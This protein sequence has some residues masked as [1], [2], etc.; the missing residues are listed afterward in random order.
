MTLRHHSIVGA[1]VTATAVTS[2]A[3]V[4]GALAA[5]TAASAASGA[6]AATASYRA[7][8]QFTTTG[9]PRDLLLHPDS[10]KL[11]VGSAD[12]PD[13]T[14]VNENGLYVLDP[15]DGKVRSTVGRAPGPTGALGPRAVGRFAGPLPGDGAAFVYPL[16]GIGTAKDGDPAVTGGWLPGATVTDVG[17]G[18]TPGTVLVAQGSVLEEVDTAAVKVGR[19]LALDG[20]TE[21]AVD[22]ARGA[23]WFADYAGRALYRVDLASFA[24]AATVRLPAGEGFGGF[25][26]V[27]PETGAVWVGLD[28]SVLVY[29]RA[30]APLGTVTGAD[31]PRA[32]A[33]DRATH[34]VFVVWQ[35]AGDPA[36]PGSDGDGTLT[37]LGSAD[38]KEAAPPVV[39][40]GNQVQLGAAAIAVAPGA[41]VVFVSD[42]AGARITRLERVEPSPTLTPAPT[43]GSSPPTTPGPGPSPTSTPG[44]TGPPGPSPAP[45]GSSPAP[46]ASTGAQ[47]PVITTGDGGDPGTAG[48]AGGGSG[49]APASGAGVSGSASGGT[50]GGAGSGAAGGA[51]ASTGVA[52]TALAGAASALLAGGGWLLARRGRRTPDA[53]DL[54]GD[55]QGPH[56]TI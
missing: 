19:T 54:S 56:G 7:V 25:V 6:P 55:R 24:V 26:E 2:V 9:R 30:G 53:G 15:A 49:G 38:R 48:G 5:G 16:R 40:P 45:S 36:S 31:L 27:D 10:G 52:V 35:D 20:G 50:V 22:A 42:P 47:V 34:Q 39:L 1:T 12:L 14:G 13:T 3:V 51:L 17:P 23:A 21:F 44:P 43:D 33:F 37:V 46:S 11:Y 8:A 41:G 4:L 18:A 32:A 29:D 28:N